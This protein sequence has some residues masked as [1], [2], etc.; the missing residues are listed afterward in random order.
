MNPG[1]TRYFGTPYTPMVGGESYDYDC[2]GS[3]EGNPSQYGAAP[4][5]GSTFLN[6]PGG[7]GFAGLNRPGNPL[8][9]SNKL[10][11]CRVNGVVCD[12]VTEAVAPKECR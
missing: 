2:S 5:C 4:V 11:S 1:Q 6:C 10:V 3:E 8:C 9:G 7:K 12:Q